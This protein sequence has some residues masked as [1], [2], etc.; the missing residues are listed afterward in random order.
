MGDEFFTAS[1]EEA[2]PEIFNLIDKEL[3]RQRD[4]I[5]LIAS[6]NIVSQAVLEATG[7]VLTN[8]YA[9]GYPGRRYYGGCEHVDVIEKIAI[10]RVTKLFN[11]RF[12]NVQAHSGAQA[13]LSAFMSV[14]QPGDTY[15]AMSL[16]DGGH[17]SHGAPVNISGKW[18]NVAPYGIDP[19]THLIDMDDVAERAR[20]YK[21]KLLLAGASA[22]SR[23]IDFAA[24]RRIADEVGAV[25]MVDM[26]HIAGL[27]A[28]GA[29]PNPVEYADI[30]TST[31]HKTLRCAR[32][33]LILTNDEARIKKLN[34]AIFPGI[35]GGPLMHIIAGKAVGFGEALKPEFRDY[36][37]NVVDNAKALAQTLM[38]AGFTILSGGTDT[39]LMLVDLSSKGIKGNQS[40][41]SLDRAAITCNKNGVPNDPES[42]MV[43]SGIRLGTPVATSRG[44]GITEFQEIGENIIETL[45][46]LVKNGDN[47]SK[48]EEKV[49]A[50]ILDLCRRFPIYPKD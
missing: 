19:K 30:V 43:T 44:L 4:G 9:E 23:I 13:N 48:V 29:H 38:Q 50:R 6:E 5:E 40:E 37:K 46:G 35:Q 10:G 14:M 42:P 41:K 7:S 17:L 39:H 22:Y 34:S 15:M 8:K 26:A 49:R 1:L 12:A 28:G 21:P 16:A 27:V 20:K 47:N 25:F 36:I 2:D 33:G 31:T 45:D 3:V 11:C 24:F 18:F 32:G